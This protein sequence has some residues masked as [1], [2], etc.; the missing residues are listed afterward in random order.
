MKESDLLTRIGLLRS[1]LVCYGC[2]TLPAGNP[3][4]LLPTSSVYPR[5]DPRLDKTIW[6]KNNLK[7]GDYKKINYA[8]SYIKGW[9]WQL[10]DQFGREKRKLLSSSTRVGTLELTQG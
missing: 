3:C 5:L 7:C 1:E 6:G 10:S 4:R 9:L 8:A 2:E